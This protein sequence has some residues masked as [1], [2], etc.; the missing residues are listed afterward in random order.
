MMKIFDED[1][2][3]VTEEDDDE[4][5]LIK[6]AIK[7]LTPVQ[8]KIYLLY[9]ETGTYT[10]TA[11]EFGVTVPTIKAYINNINGIIREYVFKMI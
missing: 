8:R 1:Y 11:N 10:A 3:V 2:T 7:S 5:V 9:V 6:E 4:M